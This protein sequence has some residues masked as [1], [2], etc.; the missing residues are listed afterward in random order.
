[1]NIAGVEIKIFTVAGRLI[2]VLDNIQGRSG[3]NQV[4]WDGRDEEND[5]LANGVYLY[6]IIATGSNDTVDAIGKAMLAR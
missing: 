6:K 1:M 5:E 4:Y 3:Q 2:R